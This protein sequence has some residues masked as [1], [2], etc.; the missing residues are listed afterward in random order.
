MN[1]EL[2]GTYKIKC[3]GNAPIPLGNRDQ[4]R[5]SR[6][7]KI[8]EAIRGEEGVCMDPVDMIVKITS[9]LLGEIYDMAQDKPL[10]IH[11]TEDAKQ[12]P[13]IA[14]KKAGDVGYDLPAVFPYKNGYKDIES[15]EKLLAL[16]S[17]DPVGNADF[18]KDP[19]THMRHSMTIMPG[20]RKLVPTGISLEIP[21]GYWVLLT[22][23]SSTSKSL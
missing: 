6:L 18:L 16:L 9:Q 4:Y 8:T 3:E 1:N 13:L 14:I 11:R 19:E 2:N 17:K 15:R 23:R 5:T 12:F 20:E 7:I 22:A 21:E 10:K